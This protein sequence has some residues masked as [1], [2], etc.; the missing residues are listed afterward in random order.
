MA[1]RPEE[2]IQVLNVLSKNAIQEK[3][4]KDASYFYWLISQI[5]LD[6]T[7]STD[8]IKTLF[9]LCYDKADIYYAYHEIYRY[10]V[11]K[12]LWYYHIYMKFMFFRFT[13]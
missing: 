10:L 11:S 8:E 7:K 9:T 1:G 3:R 2:S 13:A 4:F 5:I 12:S 6:L